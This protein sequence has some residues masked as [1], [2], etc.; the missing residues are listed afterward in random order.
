[1]A[2]WYHP[3]RYHTKSPEVINKYNEKFKLLQE[4]YDALK[5]A[6]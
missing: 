1:L 3:D 5:A 2:K 4:A 6:R